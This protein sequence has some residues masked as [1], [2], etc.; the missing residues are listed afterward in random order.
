MKIYSS[1]EE[2]VIENHI[3][4]NLKLIHK[5]KIKGIKD[6]YIAQA[7]GI[8]LHEFNKAKEKSEAFKDV[9]DDAMM[10]LCAELTD[11]VVSRATG[12]DKKKDKEGNLLGP[13]ATLAYKLLKDL[14]PRFRQVGEIKNTIT[15]E[16][17]IKEISAKR[18]KEI[19]DK[20]EEVMNEE[21]GEDEGED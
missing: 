8:S 12:K 7:I 10:I 17:I 9:Y 3:K 21:H 5:M 4:P 11:I 13:D 1:R 16:T 14:D 15:I 19:D 20:V 2:Q 6:K 18:N